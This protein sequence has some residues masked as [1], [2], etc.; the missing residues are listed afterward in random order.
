MVLVSV[1]HQLGSTMS[2]TVT[3]AAT[4]TQVMTTSSAS[5]ASGVAKRPRL[6]TDP[7]P[8]LPAT[9]ASI[10]NGSTKGASIANGSSAGAA[11]K[12]G[13]VI[14]LTIS[15]GEIRP[16][17]TTLNV[18]SGA[19]ILNAIHKDPKLA[20]SR[21][22]GVTPVLQVP[23]VVPKVPSV[24][25]TVTLAPSNRHLLNSA[26]APPT[27]S[28]LKVV[29]SSSDRGISSATAKAPAV[30][31]PRRSSAAASVGGTFMPTTATATAVVSSTT[32]T[33]KAPVTA[34]LV[35]TRSNGNGSSA[36]A[37]SDFDPLKA[38]DWSE[39]IATLPGSNL[40]FRISEFGTLEMITQKE[41]DQMG[42]KPSVTV[43]GKEKL[44]PSPAPIVIR[45]CSSTSTVSTPAAAATTGVIGTTDGNQLTTNREAPTV[46]TF[47]CCKHC[48]C[49]GM[50]VDFHSSGMFCTQSCANTF[51]A[52][53][54]N[55]KKEQD[56]LKLKRSHKRKQDSLDGNKPDAKKS[57]ESAKLTLPISKPTP[58]KQEA[59]KNETGFSWPT[60]LEKEK[61]TAV[62]AKLFKDPFPSS[63]NGFR[64]GMKLEGIDP[65]H[66]SLFC[67]LSVAEVKGFRVRLHF[68]GYCESYDFWVN[69]DSM[70]IFPVG[71]CEKAGHR[72]QPPK[73]FTSETFIWNDYLKLAKAQPAPKHLFAIKAA[74]QGITP[75]G[76]R[77][78]MKLEA[79]DKKNTALVCVATVTDVMDNRFLVHFDGWD[80]IYD[81]WA[82]LTSAYI[83]PVGWCQEN[84]HILTP[85]NKYRDPR[86]FT[87]ESYLAETK[88]QVVPARAFKQ[89][90]N[91]GMKP[92]M[93]LEVV[94]KRNPSLV[95]VA[96]IVDTNSHQLKIHF[97]GWLTAHDYWVDDDSPDIHPAGW[98]AKTGHTLQPPFTLA[99]LKVDGIGCPTPGCKGIG[100]IKGP[101]YTSHHSAFGCPY[102]VINLNKEQGGLLDR[103][104]GSKC[105]TLELKRPV[106]VPPSVS[107]SL[108][109]LTK[110]P[111]PGCDGSGHVTGIYKMHHK[112]SG[113]PLAQKQLLGTTL[114]SASDD[115]QEVMK[116]TP[117]SQGRGRRKG[118]RPASEYDFSTKGIKVE[119]E[120]EASSQTGSTSDLLA[121]VH[122]SVFLPII[123]TP[124]EMPL[125]WEQHAKLLPSAYRFQGCEVAKWNI[126][127]VTD[128]VK[129]LPG[130]QEQAKVFQ[131]EQ[132]DGEA[133]LLLNQSDLVKIMSVKLGPAL[134]V[135]NSILMFRSTL[136]S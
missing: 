9:G 117:K 52:K 17:A 79:V 7:P 129:S 75:H 107:P 13:N 116:T 101:K 74:N 102:S 77:L 124:R 38:L 54:V 56:D 36:A 85:P 125:C 3:A 128:F 122:Q 24:T 91:H 87:W 126:D 94:D 113:C 19:S 23:T 43:V 5:V 25:S 86:N 131:D 50:A 121:T 20:N 41:L 45:S 96:T 83:H 93:K 118:K 92:L 127:Q 61:A 135:Y 15:N 55:K 133:F 80:D 111:T 46:S 34:V 88:S 76:F 22:V 1:N 123:P 69:A 136:D 53:V 40:K 42:K 33:T 26:A 44:A 72:L 105:S 115:S 21:V 58:E 63:K 95:R 97:D 8:T 82:D 120:S 2:S 10:A 100:H 32:A 47:S 98:C 134:K 18:P 66:P 89:H 114:A 11:P 31:A 6:E 130:C 12:L 67:V 84:G 16:Q 81:Y 62:P 132:I 27:T 14:N 37:L 28:A 90:P 103:F 78:G 51:A 71:W 104:G 68:D 106:Y 64:V 59:V 112:L 110:C 60:Y 109:Q 119:V 73:G 99:D 4:S 30:I 108:Q 57:K 35:T 48:G 29:S 65:K 39:G 49:Y 70:D